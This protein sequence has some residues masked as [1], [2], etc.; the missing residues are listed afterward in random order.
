MNRKPIDIYSF[1]VRPHQLWNQQYLLL[2]SGDFAG[3]DFNCMTV[4]WG[5]IGTMWGRPFAQIVVR[6]TRYTYGFIERFSTFTLS[7][8]P[9]EY[10]EDL[11]LLGTKSGRDG[12][13]LSETALTPI[14]S[15]LV[16]SPAFAEAE[17]ILECR[18]LY[19]EDM[20]PARF[21]ST[22]INKQY[23]HLDFHRIYYGEI[24]RVEGVE[25]FIQSG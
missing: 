19:W 17:L 7:A 11:N 22:E 16:D 6:P 21:L 23:P 3:G 2:A 10:A 9:E 15:K 8:F 18:K 4:G 13:K 12:D 5:S 14:A 24:L 1:S 25:R 20:D